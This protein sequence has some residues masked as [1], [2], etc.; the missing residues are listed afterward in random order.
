M[1]E[2]ESPSDPE[3]EAPLHAPPSEPAPPASSP[4]AA[5]VKAP[6]DPR[7]TVRGVVA[8]TFV[9][10]AI[11]TLAS[12]V[13]PKDYSATAVGMIFLGATY[14]LV[15]RHS[16]AFIRAHGLALGGLFEPRQLD[17]KELFVDAV[18][19]LGVALLLFAVVA[20]P[21]VIGF[22]FYFHARGS[23]DFS[24]LKS[25]PKDALGQMLVIALPEEAFFRGYLQ[26]SLD[27]L[28]VAKRRIL[29]ADLSLALPLASLIFAVGH[30][31]TR[32]DPSRLA[33]FFPAL[34]F[35]YLRA[36]TKGIGTSLCFHALC[37]LLS[38]ALAEGYH[39]R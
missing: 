24:T 39:L 20:A 6:D 5:A 28:F 30:V 29:G 18:K 32:P 14:V 37:N 4:T 34:V 17:P 31:L 9:T 21:F 38:G 16:A 36:R 26:T 1:A 35:G 12:Y 15:L 33:V 2:S 23:F 7:T 11:V 10:T 27:T 22:R 25:I 8:A 13:A 19:A 3:Q